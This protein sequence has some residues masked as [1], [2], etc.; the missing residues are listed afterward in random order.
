M[1][2]GTALVSGS[3]SSEGDPCDAGEVGVFE[4]PTSFLSPV[5][6]LGTPAVG[7]STST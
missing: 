2:V 3:V 5:T 6:V 7:M 1:V 4:M